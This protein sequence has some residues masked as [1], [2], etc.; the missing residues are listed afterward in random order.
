MTTATAALDATARTAVTAGLSIAQP[1]QR[2]RPES[3]WFFI[4]HNVVKALERLPRKQQATARSVLMAYCQ[5]S[6]R[7]GNAATFS[8][9]VRLVADM[10]GV[11]DAS[12]KRLDYFFKVAGVMDIALVK[13]ERGLDAPR[14][15]TLH[16]EPKAV[17]ETY[18]ELTADE[19]RQA[20]PMRR[21]RQVAH[22]ERPVAQRVVSV[23][24]DTKE[25]IKE[26]P[27][28]TISLTAPREKRE[29][30]EDCWR[31]LAEENG[32]KADEVRQLWERHA[33]NMR[34]LPSGA[35]ATPENFRRRFNDLKATRHKS[36]TPQGDKIIAAVQRAEAERE[37]RWRSF[38][39]S[40]GVSAPSFNVADAPMR[41]QF[42]ASNEGASYRALAENW[43][44]NGAYYKLDEETGEIMTKSQ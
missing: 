22:H 27:K 15:I 25:R 26:N 7:N 34:K 28:E 16:K 38:A 5:L 33:A 24:S 35:Y 40:G 42:M 44:R 9:A 41:L 43:G 12:V 19:M 31:N 37:R 4:G 21:Q 13:D 6:S 8:A 32:M 17:A 23:V 30:V 18:E 1:C 29:S 3:G 36:V 11:S 2:Q 20:L 39:A 14:R 10:A